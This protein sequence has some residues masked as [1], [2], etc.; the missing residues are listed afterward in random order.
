VA[1]DEEIQNVAIVGTG[2][3]GASGTGG[4]GAVGFLVKPFDHHLLLK[5][6]VLHLGCEQPLRFQSIAGTCNCLP[7]NAALAFHNTRRFRTFTCAIA[8]KIGRF[9][10]ADRGTSFGMR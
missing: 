9:E 5:K 4:H 3:I 1:K 2:V 6:P 7:R 10:M 8:R